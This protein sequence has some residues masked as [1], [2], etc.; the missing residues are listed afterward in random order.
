MAVCVVK[1]SSLDRKIIGGNINE[2]RNRANPLN[3]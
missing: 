3:I 1:H 2:V